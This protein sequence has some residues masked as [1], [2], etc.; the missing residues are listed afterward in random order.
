MHRKLLPDLLKGIAVILMIQV[1]IME[2]FAIQDIQDSLLGKISLFLGGPPC[3]PV[4]MVVMGYFI[5]FRGK[6]PYSIFLRGLKL[7]IIGLFLNIGLNLHLLIKIFNKSINLNPLDFIFGVDILILAGLSFIIC[8]FLTFIFQPATDSSLADKKTPLLYFILAIVIAVMTPYMNNIL[9]TDT[10]VK[11][12]YAIIGGNYHW[13]YFPLFP[14]LAYPLLG[15]SF[16][17]FEKKYSINL[18]LH[19][20]QIVMLI[21][22]AVGLIFTI[23]YAVGISSNL[24][25]YYHHNFLFFFWTILFL[26]FYFSL[27]LF[28]ENY[29]GNTTIFKYLKFAGKNVIV[30]YIFQWLIIGNIATAIYKTQNLFQIILWFIGIILITSL[31]V[32]LYKK[33]LLFS[34]SCELRI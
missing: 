10:A 8:S 14:W 4:F 18:P 13:S 22:L 23:K 15:Y 3:A 9:P 27:F 17:F 34:N 31:L 25:E 11:Y 6:S 29:L 12:F 16:Y 7:L 32:Y 19:K 2:L 30:F 26:I 20:S 21:I 5:A 33:M 1:H 24:E 28:A